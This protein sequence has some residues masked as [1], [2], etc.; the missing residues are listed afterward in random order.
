MQNVTTLAVVG[1]QTL[2]CPGDPE[3]VA[4]RIRWSI[5]RLRPNVVMS[6]GAAGVDTAAEVVARELGY[7]E[8][9]GT[10]VVVRPQVRRWQG[11]GGFQE[12]NLV[13]A[14]RCTHLLRLACRQAKTYGSGWTADRAAELGKSVV[15]EVICRP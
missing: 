10:L 4:A 14:Q 6:G 11:P 3:R 9:E 1:T 8:D 2:A 12:R 5:E 7:R 15:R 13:I